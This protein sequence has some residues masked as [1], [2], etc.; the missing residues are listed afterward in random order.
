MFTKSFVKDLAERAIKTFAQSAVAVLT[1][2]ATGVLDVDWVNVLS[3]SL[4]ATIVSILTSVASG[5][6]GDDT[7]SFVKIKGE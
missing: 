5:N 7:A 3:V 2:G 1:A 6:V 4:L